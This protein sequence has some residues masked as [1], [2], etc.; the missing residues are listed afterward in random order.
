MAVSAGIR[1]CDRSS[2]RSRIGTFCNGTSPANMSSIAIVLRGDRGLELYNLALIEDWIDCD[3]SSGRSR[4]G[5]G[6]MATTPRSQFIAIVLR[7]DRGLEQP[8]L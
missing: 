7:G 8:F 2:G 6:T 5:T 3:R 4:I 1:H